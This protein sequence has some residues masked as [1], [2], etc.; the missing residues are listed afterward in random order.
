MIRTLANEQ[1]TGVAR[2]L[3]SASRA[4]F[5]VALSSPSSSGELSE[6]S[7][8]I[9]S[10]QDGSWDEIDFTNMTELSD[11]ILRSV[12]VCTDA[13]NKLKTLRLE[14]CSQIVGHGLEPIRES[15]VLE[16]ITLFMKGDNALSVNVVIPI[17]LDTLREQVVE[18]CIFPLCD[19]LHGLFRN[20]DWLYGEARLESPLN[21]ALVEI[22]EWMRN[23]LSG[24]SDNIC[25]LCFA[26]E[27]SDNMKTCDSCRMNLCISCNS[28]AVC[29]G[30]ES[31]YCEVCYEVGSA[32]ACDKCPP[33]LVGLNKELSEENEQLKKENE[34]LRSEIEK[35]KLRK[36]KK[37]D[38]D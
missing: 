17:L 37:S 34:Q 6:A 11:D 22:N 13:K 3:P 32:D 23:E 12:L 15:L 9:L 29:H 21:E 5:A 35:L 33:R 20:H 38:H 31:V 10:N 36:R 26:G 24:Y 28:M 7:I 27:T 25:F 4:R 18:G 30:C 14:G 1:L 19:R 16:R 2:Y 8:L